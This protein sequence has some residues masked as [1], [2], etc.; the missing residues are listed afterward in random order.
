MVVP[1]GTPFQRH[2]S[3]SSRSAAKVSS[4]E[5]GATSFWLLNGDYPSVE[6]SID[7]SRVTIALTKSP[8]V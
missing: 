5:S 3:T 8:A 2:E 1:K 6:Y 4:C 7:W